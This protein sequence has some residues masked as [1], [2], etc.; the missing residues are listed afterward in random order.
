MVLARPVLQCDDGGCVA[1]KVPIEDLMKDYV[2]QYDSDF[3]A[4]VR[5]M[6]YGDD[7]ETEDEE[8]SGDDEDDGD[9]D[10]GLWDS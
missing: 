3:E 7:G 9:E 10:T 6:A 2:D 8:D 1:D 5:A 4:E